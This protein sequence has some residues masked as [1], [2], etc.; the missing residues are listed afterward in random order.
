LDNDGSDGASPSQ[1]DGSDGASP[2]Q[3][4]GSDGASPS[5]NE[6]SDGASPSQNDGSDGASPSQNAGSDGASPYQN[7]ALLRRKTDEPISFGL[8]DS[9]LQRSLAIPVSAVMTLKNAFYFRGSRAG[10]REAVTSFSGERRRYGPRWS[11]S[12]AP[13]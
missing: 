8:S 6:G 7:A 13:R 5:Q 4:E 10:A 2:S 11:L 12:R 9:R 3:N 1:N